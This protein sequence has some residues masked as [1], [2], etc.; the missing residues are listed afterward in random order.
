MPLWFRASIKNQFDADFEPASPTRDSGFEAVRVIPEN[1]LMPEETD[2]LDEVNVLR[3]LCAA[4]ALATV[5]A[6]IAPVVQP[7]GPGREILRTQYKS[8]WQPLSGLRTMQ[9]YHPGQA[10]PQFAVLP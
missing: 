1:P 7:I 9:D 2:R 3:P 4:S 10:H 6:V 5:L 8:R